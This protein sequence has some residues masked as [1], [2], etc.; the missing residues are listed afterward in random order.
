MRRSI[1][2]CTGRP[3]AVEN[4][5]AQNASHVEAGNSSAEAFKADSQL[6]GFQP[7]VAWPG[8]RV[9]HLHVTARK[10]KAWRGDD[11]SLSQGQAVQ[12]VSSC[13]LCHWESMFQGWRELWGFYR[14]PEGLKFSLSAYG[15]SL[16]KPR[17]GFLK[18]E[19]YPNSIFLPWVS[20]IMYLSKYSWCKMIT[21]DALE[22]VRSLGWANPC[23]FTD[24]YQVTRFKFL[25]A[26]M[27]T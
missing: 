18:L 15:A 22:R 11:S 26:L 19:G 4:Y 2:E 5:L 27:V 13:S 20:K 6:P 14:C 23:S 17:P 1:P 21:L 24:C 9:F 25:G 3:S 12:R 7:T 10:T 8:K 16:V